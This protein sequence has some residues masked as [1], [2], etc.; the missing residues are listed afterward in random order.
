MK[1][2]IVGAGAIGSWIGGRL[3]LAG[4]DVSMLARGETLQEIDA[5]GLRL[6]DAGDTRCVAV[7]VSDDPA[8]LGVHDILV[9]AV[10]APALPELAPTLWPLIDTGTQIIPMSPCGRSTPSFISPTPCR[11]SRSSDASSTR[12]AFEMRPT[13]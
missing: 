2:C 7:A 6:T 10:K 11:S 13:T 3:A 4:S 12:A 1:I 8:Q 9:L 5:T